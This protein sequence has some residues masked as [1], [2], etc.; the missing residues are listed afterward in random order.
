MISSGDLALDILLA[1]AL[2]FILLMIGVFK[3]FFLV[4]P[5]VLGLLVFILLSLRRGY[6]VKPTLLMIWK[7]ALKAFPL[8]KIFVLIGVI[9]AMWMA[10]GTI[11]GIVFY[12]ID[13]INPR[14]FIISA[15]VACSIVSFMLG[16][17]LGTSGT[18]GVAMIV[19]AR[20]GNVNINLAAGAI[21]AGAFFGDR[22]SPMSSS[23]M[24]VASITGT[25]IYRN[26]RNMLKTAILPFT[27]AAAIYLYLSV[28]NPLIFSTSSIRKELAG[29]FLIN[30]GMLLP[31]AVILVL[32]LMKVD[33]KA[34]MILSIIAAIIQ[35]LA[36]QHRGITE[37]LGFSL[38]G[39]NLG[40][41][42]F[43]SSVIKGGGI[44]TMLKTSAIV[45]VSS[46]YAG[47]FE[48]T[49]MLRDVETAVEKI[50]KR[51]GLFTATV[52]MSASTA[53]FGCSQA[54]AIIMTHQLVKRE[55]LR[56]GAG[57]G[58]LAVDLENTAV[59]MSPL[60]PW[61]ISG[62][63]PAAALSVG[64]GFIAYAFFLYLVPLINL[65]TRAAKAGYKRAITSRLQG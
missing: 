36:F 31:A 4:Y 41:G 52:V 3:G 19:L 39:F 63:L 23:A 43:L 27:A 18:I 11:A 22:C 30:P 29:H 34:A 60:V 61:N 58:S 25:D 62:A 49:G 8:I 48:G 40:D 5:L 35:A 21:I 56:T 14:Y 45:I 20:S 15:F 59:V 54:L 53:V 42:S 28:Q 51:L 64:P 44:V 16:T 47:I 57:D 50:S 32:A 10:S 9:I 55:Y 2:T 17:S 65:C 1:F 26:I 12:V 7:G 33:V 24:L 13:F 46:S 37:L 6:G 38:T